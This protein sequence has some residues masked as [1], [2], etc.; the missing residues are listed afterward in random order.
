MPN[1]QGT[2]LFRDRDYAEEGKLL[3]FLQTERERGVVVVVVVEEPEVF[4]VY[5]SR[6]ICH[7][8]PIVLNLKMK[9]KKIN[10]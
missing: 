2:L 5:N 8:S 1:C 6:V 4:A 9:K 10:L 3:L 7:N